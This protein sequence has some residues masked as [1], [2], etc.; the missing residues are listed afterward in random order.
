MVAIREAYRNYSPPKWVRPTVE[1]LLAGAAAP[2]SQLGA[3]VLTNGAAVG[4]GKTRRVAGR[5]YRRDVCLGFYRRKHGSEPASIELVIDNTIAGLRFPF[6]RFELFREIVV[7]RTLFHELGHH[8][9]A[10]IGAPARSGEAAA[11]AWRYRL[12]QEYFQKQYWWLKPLA[13]ILR[14]VVKRMRRRSKAVVA[15]H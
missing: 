10:T 12:S 7:A 15:T 4:E 3:V 2:V 13:R 11:E 8:L 14:P 6:L 5:K 1:R 9:D